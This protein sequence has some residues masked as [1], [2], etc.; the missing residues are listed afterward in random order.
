MSQGEWNWSSGEHFSY[1]TSISL[2]RTGS[3]QDYAAMVTR[4]NPHFDEWNY[5]SGGW[6]DTN[7]LNPIVPDAKGIAEIPLAQQYT[8]RNPNTQVQW[9]VRSSDRYQT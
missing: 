6:H 8:H 5:V 9:S 7:N 1:S 4:F 2:L 3:E